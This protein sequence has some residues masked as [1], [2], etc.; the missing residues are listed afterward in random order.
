MIFYERDR[1]VL[2]VVHEHSQPLFIYVLD[3]G[4]SG[5]IYPLYPVVGASEALLPGCVLEVGK[6]QHDEKI[7]A[8]PADFPFR[9]PGT[10]TVEGVETWK[11]FATTHATD[12]HPL[13]QGAV[14]V[15]DRPAG[16]VGALGELLAV[17]FE[18]GGCRD[19]LPP[20]EGEA[21]DWIALERSFRL[22]R[23]RPGRVAAR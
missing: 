6:R 16:P 13:L 18:G 5:R 12:F 10:E 19:V 22:R 9:D 4:L 20:G 21:E 15:H 8:F 14:R 23:P 17:T 1:A 11:V 2:R 7:L 3:L